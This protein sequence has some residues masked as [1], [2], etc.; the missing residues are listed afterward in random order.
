MHSVKCVHTDLKPENVLFKYPSCYETVFDQVWVKISEKVL[1]IFFL[2]SFGFQIF[3]NYDFQ[4][5]KAK[6]KT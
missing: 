4:S 1:N 6:T 2:E 3:L 5:I